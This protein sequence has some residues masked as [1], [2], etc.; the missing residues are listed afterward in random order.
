M[1]LLVSFGVLGLHLICI[2]PFNQ[3]RNH[4][5][6]PNVAN[7]SATMLC[8][9]VAY[10]DEIHGMATRGTRKQ[11]VRGYRPRLGGSNY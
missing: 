1:Q 3:Q 8:D 7:W 2:Q 6:A 5:L 11:A 9:G 10:E 4:V